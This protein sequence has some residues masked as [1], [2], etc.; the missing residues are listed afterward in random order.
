MVYRC[1]A[2]R[3]PQETTVYLIQFFCRGKN[4]KI[5][6][7]CKKEKKNGEKIGRFCEEL[8]VFNLCNA[9]SS[10]ISECT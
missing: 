3:I 10:F 6:G 8:G 5:G 9:F 2:F 1:F 4:G 7:E